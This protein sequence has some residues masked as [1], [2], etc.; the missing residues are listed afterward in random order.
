MLHPVEKTLLNSLFQSPI[1][2]ITVPPGLIFPGGKVTVVHRGKDLSGVVDSLRIFQGGEREIEML[3][4]SL[5]Q[6]PRLLL[7]VLMMEP[8]MDPVIFPLGP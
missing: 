4:I 2:G 8:L 3:R 6:D 5:Q 1:L 7:N